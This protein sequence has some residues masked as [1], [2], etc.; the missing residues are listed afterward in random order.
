MRRLFLAALLAAGPAVAAEIR[1]PAQCSEAVAADPAAAREGAA[2][3]QR[4]GGGVPAR[5]C[6]AEALSA[7]GAHA[8]AGRLLTSL[9]ANP[10]RAMSPGLR[11]VILTDGARQWLAAGRPDL[12]R[13]ALAVAGRITVADADRQILIARAAAAEADWPAAQA[14]LEAALAERPDDAV[15]HALLAAALRNQDDPAAALTEAERA[16]ALDPALPEALF[17]TGAALAETGQSRRAAQVWLELI[18]AHPDTSLAALARANLQRL[19]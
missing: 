19:N 1:T 8:T 4:M 17:E 12:A 16:R 10:N 3:W 18:A 13:A 9:A 6:E 14:A 11:A 2:V 7:M 5:L 15:A